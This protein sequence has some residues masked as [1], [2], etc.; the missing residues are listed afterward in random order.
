VA[1]AVALTEHAFVTPVGL[2][3]I[4]PHLFTRPLHQRRSD[5]TH[6]V[7]TFHLFVQVIAVAMAV[8][9]LELVFAT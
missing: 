1:M 5:L 8:V 9:N 7:L 4:V 3:V 6:R 2:Q